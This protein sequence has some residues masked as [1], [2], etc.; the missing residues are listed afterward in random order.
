MAISSD[1]KIAWKD[2]SSKWI[3]NKLSRIESHKIRYKSQAILTTSKTVTKDNPRFTVRN[4]NKVIKYLPVIIID[5]SLKIPLDSYLLK[6]VSKRR[7]I[8][9][10]SKKGIKYQ[11]LKL[12]GCEV[13]LMKKQVKT[14]DFNISTIMRKIFSLKINDILIESGGIFFTKIISKSLVDEIHIFKAPFDIGNGGKPMLIKKSIE[15]FNYQ[16]ISKNKLGKDVYHR[17]IKKD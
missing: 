11:K 8:I 10:T 16:E 3:S 4:K 14:N 7:I 5:K 2:Y 6:T 17:F 9:F 12:L 13:Y 15:E 1:N